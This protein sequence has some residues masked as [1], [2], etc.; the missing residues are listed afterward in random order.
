MS[1]KEYITWEVEKRKNKTAWSRT[2]IEKEQKIVDEM[3][4][5]AAEGDKLAMLAFLL[6][7][8]VVCSLA[9][10][11]IFT[12]IAFTMAKNLG[13]PSIEYVSRDLVIVFQWAF[14]WQFGT[15]ILLIS[16]HA[17]IGRLI[18]QYD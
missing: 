14:G 1:E 16:V 2:D 13:Y 17:R 6:F 11:C 4:D 15:G 8:L 3:E 5:E 9:T 10:A 7:V 18:A 12:G